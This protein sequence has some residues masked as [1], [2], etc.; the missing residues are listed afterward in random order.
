MNAKLLSTLAALAALAGAFS[1]R[2]GTIMAVNLPPTNTDIATG[3][4]TNKTY[5]C[6]FDYGSQNTT[7]YSV[8]GVPFA[9]FKTAAQ[10]TYLVTNWIDTNAGHG[11]QV[12]VTTSAANHGIDDT[13]SATQGSVANQAD[14]NM[15][16]ILT[17][18]MYPGN[19][20]PVG[21][22]IQQ[23][24]DN[25]TI[26]H[27]YSLRIYYRYW[28]NS[29][30]DRTQNFSFNGEGTWQA[31]SGNP[32]DE[33]AGTNG[34]LPNG[35]ICHGA[36]FLQYNFTAS[37]TNVFCLASNLVA[38]GAT[39]IEGATLEDDSYPYAPFITYE[40]FVSGGTSNTFS[41]GVT[42]IGTPSL[43]YQ[44]YFNTESNYSGATM[45]ND[46]ADYSGATTSNLTVMSNYFDYYFV[47]V[48]N[49][50]GSITSSI[51]QINPPPII[52]TQPTATKVGSSVVFNVMAVGLPPLTFQWY[53]NTSS[54][55]SGATALTDGNGYTGSG[56]SSLT[57]GTNFL[58]YYFVTA[59][60]SSGVATSSIVLLAAPMTVL[61][62]GEPIWNQAGQSNVVVIFSDVLDPVTS[63]T[64]T[65]YSLNN[66]AS[67]H[68]ATMVAPSE[69]VLG[70]SVLNPTNS[71]TLTVQ[72][73]KDYFGIPMTP[74]PTNLT[75]GIYPSE[76]AL[77][78]R[79]NTGVTTDPGT[80]SV[81][82]WNDL[83]G[84]SNNL[85]QGIFYGFEEPLLETNALGD[86]VLYF[87]GTNSPYGTALLANDA[88]SL[89]IV[90]DISIIAVV[91]FAVPGFGNANGEIVSK[92]GAYDAA[93]AAPYDY[94]VA[95]TG[96]SLY[97]GDGIN[98][99]NGYAWYTANSGPSAGTTHI[100]AVT[101]SGNNISHYVDGQLAGSGVLVN[102]NGL[103]TAFTETNSAD[104][105]Q[106]VVVGGRGDEVVNHLTGDLAEL[107][108]V[109]SALSTSDLA[110]LD[111]YLTLTHRLNF[112]TPADITVS[113]AANQLTLA[114][115]AGQIGWEL[116][117]NSVGL[118]AANAWFAVPG[119]TNTN[120]ITITLPTN[121][122]V[123]YRTVYPPQ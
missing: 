58:D 118:A 70:T 17:D 56:T 48:T 57:V 40:P 95:S 82:E 44:W 54:N 29:P 10:N 62:A 16:S 89:E 79:A 39:M 113:K 51:A 91:N 8:N 18:L 43:D 120:Q 69:V 72:N 96:A 41:F 119:S 63:A 92:T 66:G 45:A 47:I 110:S 106:P 50:Q 107:I 80:N 104:Q 5:V 22:W 34:V 68:S 49:N 20:A 114:W 11:G 102:N 46:G 97:R 112:L 86:L 123:F 42:A 88:P 38:N 31:Y 65:N 108:V 23:E 28:G 30:G 3:I 37:A 32:L 99:G 105:G 4:T 12:I 75:V 100:V 90:G 9:H 76:V 55:Y 64:A 122:A 98:S 73:V 19:G 77:W 78:V 84:N 60:N 14:G 109:G 2:A 103:G 115:P 101:E 117:S 81:N 33:D 52:L 111:N 7:T 94:H 36:R 27:P 67:V 21:G 74:S 13:S 87:D 61:S 6:A 35:L 59:S 24:Y 121:Q 116:Q 93:I 83:S 25:L 26:G 15:R 71:Y 85:A 1:A 53:V